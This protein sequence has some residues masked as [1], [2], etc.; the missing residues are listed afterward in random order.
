MNTFVTQCPTHTLWFERVAKGMHYR[1]RDDRHPD[2]V[3]SRELMNDLMSKV[4]L[5]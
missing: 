3:V 2:V 5:D 4:N 1:I